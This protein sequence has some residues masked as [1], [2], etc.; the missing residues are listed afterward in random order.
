MPCNCHSCHR[1]RAT[2]KPSSQE[3]GPGKCTVR[4]LQTNRKTTSR[5]NGKLGGEELRRQGSRGEDALHR[6]RANP[7]YTRRLLVLMEPAG[8]PGTIGF[9]EP[10]ATEKEKGWAGICGTE[11]SE[12]SGRSYDGGNADCLPEALRAMAKY[13]TGQGSH[14]QLCGQRSGLKET[15]S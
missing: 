2:Y 6:P 15:E 3:S 1:D 14:F 9:L 11:S 12:S 5:G 8:K 10:G 7:V 4:R 13:G